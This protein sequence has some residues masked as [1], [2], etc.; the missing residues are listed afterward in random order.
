MPQG[1]SPSRRT[2]DTQ[3]VA[4]G[5]FFFVQSED[6]AKHGGR[7]ERRQLGERRE[8]VTTG[9]VRHLPGL[10]DQLF[11]LHILFRTKP[12]LICPPTAMFAR[13]LSISLALIIGVAVAS[14]NLHVQDSDF[15]SVKAQLP[16]L[17]TQTEVISAL[18][19]L[20]FRADRL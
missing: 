3:R 19:D 5:I 7:S 2:P 11:Y 10:A 17:S 14:V 18:V 9:S 8:G 12:T 1:R 13:P 4:I 6:S 20:P 15:L 16:A